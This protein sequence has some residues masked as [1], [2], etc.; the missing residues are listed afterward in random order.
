MQIPLTLVT[1]WSIQKLIL[2]QLSI[3]LEIVSELFLF[4][5]FGIELDTVISFIDKLTITLSKRVLVKAIVT[6]PKVIM[7]R[8]LQNIEFFA[9]VLKTDILG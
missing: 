6:A 7:V 5:Q 4:C 9:C 3:L 2:Q 8:T 1:L